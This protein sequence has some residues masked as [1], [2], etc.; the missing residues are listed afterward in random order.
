MPLTYRAAPLD[1]AVWNA[2][3]AA[4]MLT[5]ATGAEEYFEVDGRPETR[6]TREPS[7][8]VVGSGSAGT[9]VPADAEV[10]VVHRVGEAVD[11]IAVLT[12][13]RAGGGG[14][15]AAVRTVG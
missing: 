4:T 12:G 13:S 6:E 7:V 11:G 15:L 2:A 3:V 5:G 10:V 14:T 1:G 8:H 9:A